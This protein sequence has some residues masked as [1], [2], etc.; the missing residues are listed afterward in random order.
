MLF[1][2]KIGHV[3]RDCRKKKFQNQRTNYTLTNH[4]QQ[5][6]NQQRVKE[7]SALVEINPQASYAQLHQLIKFGFGNVPVDHLEWNLAQSISSI[8]LLCCLIG[9]SSAVHT[10]PLICLPE[11]PTSF[12]RLPVQ[13]KTSVTICR[14][15]DTYIH[16]SR[17]IFGGHWE[18]TEV[19]QKE[20]ASSTCQRMKSLNHSPAVFTRFGLDHIHTPSGT[21]T[22]CRYQEGTCR[23]EQGTLLWTPDVTQQC[24]Y[25]RINAWI[26]T[27]SSGIWLKESKDFA[28]SFTNSTKRISCQQEMLLA[29]QGFAVPLLEYQLTLQQTRNRRSAQ[30]GTKE[31]VGLIY[32]NQ[33][34]SQLTALSVSQFQST[35]KMFAT[36]VQHVCASMQTIAESTMTLAIANPTLLARYMLNNTKISARMV[37]ENMLEV[38]PCLPIRINDFHF[39]TQEKCFDRL[40][41][42]FV[43][44]GRIHSGFI[45]P[46]TMIIK[47]DAKEKPCATHRIIL[48]PE[49]QNRMKQYDQQTGEMR[50]IEAEEIHQLTRFGNIDFPEAP[51]S[52]TIFH[53]SVLANL[54]ELYSPEHFAETIEAATINQEIFRLASTGEVWI[55]IAHIKPSNWLEIL[56]ERDFFHFYMEGLLQ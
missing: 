12:W 50:Y 8:L 13:Y 55:M 49:E 54:T 47:P 48:L 38:R 42:N 52:P 43:L 24:P 14:C 7:I 26:G 10:P 53:N 11:A 9:V 21:C 40:P 5:N 6:K 32:S 22:E 39:K 27:F 19:K 46:V 23:C 1:C 31:K 44:N 4:F 18:H 25:I 56:S 41:V 30:E 36:T 2:G 33:L 35:Q 34:A 15:I 29:D 51:N 17:S 28:L 45:D 37:S 16:R 20:V 3:I